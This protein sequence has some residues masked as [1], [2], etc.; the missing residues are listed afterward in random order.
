M[1]LLWLILIPLLGGLLGWVL[2]LRNPRWSR[3]IALLAMLLQLA[4]AVELWLLYGGHAAGP[5]A[6]QWLLRMSVPW[7][8]AIGVS[9]ALSLDGLSLLLIL[10]TA[11][12]GVVSVVISWH[13]ISE[14][15]GFYHLNLLFVLAGITG[16]FLATD[17]F[18]FYFF[19]EL[20]LVP[21][22]L[23]IAIWG[24]ENRR[25]AA[26]KFFLFTQLSGL[27]MLLAIL[28]LFFIHGS[29]TGEYTFDY[30]RLLGTPLAP[31]VA[32]WLMLGFF[33]AFAVKLP[34]VPVHT[35]LPDAHTEAPTAGSVIL[36][37]LLLKTG[38][39][40]LIRFV[41]PLF[42]DSALAFAPI[43]MILG[44]V[45]II[46]GAVLAFAQTDAKRL[47]A[48][49]SISHLGFVLLG[50]FAWVATT[51]PLSFTIPGTLAVQGAVMQ[52]LAHGVST[53]ALFVLVGAL[54]DRLHTRD[55]RRMGG[56]WP[57]LPILGGMAILFSMASLGLPGLGNFL[58]EFLVLLGTWPVSVPLTAIGAAGMLFAMIYSLWLI[59]RVF[60]GQPRETWHPTDLRAPDVAVLA[61]MVAV[62]VWLG[63]LPRAVFTTVEPVFRAPESTTTA[64]LIPQSPSL[65]GMS[66]REDR[67]GGQP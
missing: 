63:L 50:I 43:A 19:W 31:N 28:G 10:L 49:S 66:L 15:V 52:M 67:S 18:L 46:Y 56:L 61:A 27:L 24:H 7:I 3:L 26:T 58:G 30:F 6:G 8:P 37:G 13:G 14:R 45:G 41:I 39:Y 2:G 16:V 12:L 65:Q 64:D 55:M 5:V 40:G 33:I 44:V 20:M 34:V 60:L 62:I 23:L 57:A 11:F 32:M 54:Q 1:M 21:M 4:L 17:L 29:S 59:Q 47:V 51:G 35:W 42:P 25:Y 22:Y 48:Y 53:G 38:G 36:A 9:F